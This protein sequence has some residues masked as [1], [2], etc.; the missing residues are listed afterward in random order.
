MSNKINVRNVKKTYNASSIRVLEGLDAVKKRP[1]MYIGDTDDGSGLHQMVFEV[2]DNSI[3]EALAG[4]C[5]EIS[6]TLYNNGYISVLDNGRGMPVDMH[7]SGKHACEVIMCTLHAGGKFDNNAYKISGGL[8]GVGISVVNALSVDLILEIKRDGKHYRQ[9]FSNGNV[10]SKLKLIGSTNQSGTY[11]KFKPNKDIFS[12]VQFKFDVLAMH[13]REQAFLNRGILISIKYEN[14]IDIHKFYFKDGIIDF[15]K[16]LNGNKTLLHTELIYIVDEQDIDKK[17]TKCVVE[18]AM[19]WNNT[20]RENIVCFTNN[21]KNNDG[22]THLIGF[23]SSL[24]RTLNN[25]INNTVVK[26]TSKYILS[27]EDIREGLTGIISVK[28]ED[29][30]FSSQTKD[31]LVSSEIRSVVEHVLSDALIFWLEE[32]PNESKLICQKIINSYKARMAARKAREISRISGVYDMLE[33]PGKLADCQEKNPNLN[34]LFI[35]EGDSAGGSAKNGRDR[36]FQAILPLKGKILNVEKA[37]FDQIISNQEIN[38][39]VATLGSGIG[40]DDFNI[41]KLRYH[42]IILMTDADIDGSH[43]RMLLL[44]FFY[45]QMKEIIE[46]G[47][48]YIAQPP[49]YKIQKGKYGVYVKDDIELDNYFINNMLNIIKIYMKD[50]LIKFNILQEALLSL[51]AFDRLISIVFN[52]HDIIIM[53]SIILGTNLNIENFDCFDGEKLQFML[54]KF[55]EHHKYDVLSVKVKKHY[56]NEVMSFVINITYNGIVYDMTLNKNLIHNVKFKKLR[57]LAYK[58]LFLIKDKFKMILNNKVFY[59]DNI[60]KLLNILNSF[61]KDGYII[62]RY[63]GLGEMNPDQ[64]WNTTMNPENRCLFKVTIKDAVK[65]DQIFSDLM[66]D[67]VYPRKEFIDTISFN[68]INANV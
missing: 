45:R 49:L 35:V 38:T 18:I 67:D 16:Y 2:I 9:C 17:N 24:T 42:K 19:Q 23:R 52:K 50:K 15:L 37:R 31:K 11:I 26:N 25:Y 51:Y 61:R 59:V 34:E 62:Q 4:Y 39:L 29:P 58:F 36:S 46:K 56:V 41:N 47:F 6:I 57:N 65:A 21:I 33:L 64:L 43:I 48:L 32:H 5:N 27:G 53:R 3:D 10:V 1:G 30:K 68:S 7:N 22:G 8:H 40:I 63:K 44:T 12:N 66:G 13:I 60:N 28:M 55:Y 20:Y 14:L 54:L